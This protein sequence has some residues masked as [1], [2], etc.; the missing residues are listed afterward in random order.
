MPFTFLAHQAPVLP[1][2]MK[3]PHLWDGLALVVGSMAPDL[4]KVSTGW[5]YGP[6]GLRL[7]FDGHSVQNQLV[8]AVFAA[9]LTVIVRHAVLPVAPLVL[10]DRLGELRSSL[11]ASGHRRP[12][13]WRTYLSALVGAVTHIVL[14]AITHVDGFVAQNVP[15]LSTP[16]FTVA[17]KEVALSKLLQYIA[18]VVLGVWCVILLRRWWSQARPEV[19]PAILRRGG[20]VAVFVGAGLGAAVGLLVAI[21]RTGPKHWRGHEYTLRFPPILITWCWVAFGGLLLGCLVARPFVTSRDR[22][23]PEGADAPP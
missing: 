6:L 18:T 13:L 4:A 21:S 17:G 10:P 11:L 23:I 3:R 19:A 5:G 9:L 8:L 22:S 12:E 2:T 14:D 20:R 1:L 16:W 7:Y 15:F